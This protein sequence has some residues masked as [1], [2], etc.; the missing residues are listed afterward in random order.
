VPVSVSVG[1]SGDEDTSQAF[2]AAAE[3]AAAGLDGGC[4]LCV[5]FIGAAHLTSAETVLE[6]VNSRLSPVALIGCGAGGVIGGGRE[7]EDDAGAVVWALSAPGAE[8]ETFALTSDA[9]DGEVA[10]GGLPKDPSELGDV[11][12][13]LADPNSF[14]AD[15][16]LMHLNDARP[17]M[18]VLGGLASAA[19]ERSACL[20]LDT[21][22]I[23]EGAVAVTL[24]GV[25]ILPCV[26]QGA[27]PVGPEMTV[28][29]AE[30]NVVSELASKPALDRLREVIE[31]LD[32]HEQ[33]LAAEG[34]LIGVVI[35]E[36]QPEYERGDFLV[37]PIVGVDPG[38]GAVAIASQMRVGQTVRIHVR[39]ASSA[40][41]D[42]RDALATR[43]LAL[44]DAGAAGTLVFSCNGRGSQM[45]DE[46]SH[47][48]GVLA[49]VLDAPAGGFFAA[50]EI[51]PVGG[52]N[53][54]H[55]FTATMA[56]FPRD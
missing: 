18:P 55:G 32:H 46:P 17:S 1:V 8:V 36:N 28:T 15:A 21:E 19:M 37:R 25:E 48:A 5:V 50:G 2:I 30:G 4:D 24:R 3:D 54:L 38:T 56:V 10:L 34:L 40:S 31:D 26:S 44:G 45:F 23:D 43:A 29:G 7:L 27:A 20:L 9:L 16:L 33:A 12:F 49:D 41:D 22:V 14:S 51:G 11:M 13:V 52:R 42:L 35:D 53:F 47:D 6:I 39:D